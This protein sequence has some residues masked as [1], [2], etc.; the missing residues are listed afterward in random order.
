M[1]ASVKAELGVKQLQVLMR[2]AGIEVAGPLPGDLQATSVFS[3]AIMS[4]AKD[5]PIELSHLVLTSP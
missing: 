2:V 3:S 5:R 1:V 4:G